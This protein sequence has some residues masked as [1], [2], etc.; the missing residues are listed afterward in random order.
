LDPNGDIKT[1]D[2]IY[3]NLKKNGKLIWGAPVGKEAIVWNVHRI[4][5]KIRLPLLFKKFKELE[6]IRY[7][8]TECLNGIC[9]TLR[10]NGNEGIYEQPVVVLEKN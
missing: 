3:N 2:S 10:T 7:N 5:G 4:Y 8:K 1:M 9:K 6:W